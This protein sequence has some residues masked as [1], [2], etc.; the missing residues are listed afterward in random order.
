MQK[1][2]LGLVC[3]LLVSAAV[4]SACTQSK[5]TLIG[6]GNIQQTTAKSADDCCDKCFALGYKCA[7]FTFHTD[8]SGA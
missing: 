8:G 6:E 7:A 3:L 4:G 5:D 2:L 1:L